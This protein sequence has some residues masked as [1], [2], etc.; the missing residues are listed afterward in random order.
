MSQSIEMQLTCPQCGTEFN[1]PA[2]TVVDMANEAD[3]EALW[4]L[5]NG[6]LNKAECPNCQAAGLIPVPVVLNIPEQE[7][8]LVFVPGAYQMD[9]QQLG[10]LIG[11]VLQTYIGNLPEEEQ[12][13]YLLS[14]IVTDDL[15]ALQQASRGELA[16]DEFM[17][18]ASEEDMEFGEE[19][20]GD[21]EDEESEL[22]PE[23]QQDL[24]ERMQLLQQLFQA[25]DSLERISMMRASKDKIDDLFLEVIGLLNEQA[26]DQQ[27]D[28]VP[29]LQKI[30]NE[31]EVF[32]ASNQV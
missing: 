32:I 1:S 2:H 28:L 7:K 6:T 17:A 9:E 10:S 8:L 13:E 20:E 30:M 4:Q 26:E 12:H 24:I 27:P 11:P 29:V 23:E 25:N 5:Q 15:S 21:E 18:D 3:S 31:A 22:S 14:P 16:L 19:E